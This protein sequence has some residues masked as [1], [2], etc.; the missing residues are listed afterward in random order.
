MLADNS[1]NLVICHIMEKL[2]LMLSFSSSE[3]YVLLELR[4][5]DAGWDFPSASEFLF[6]D[7]EDECRGA[8]ICQGR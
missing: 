7:L 6:G 3:I 8:E 2:M 4:T 1:H 5:E